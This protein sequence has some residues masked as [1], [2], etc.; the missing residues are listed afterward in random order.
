MAPPPPVFNAPTTYVPG[1]AS[2]DNPGQDL[3]A[4]PVGTAYVLQPVAYAY[5]VI[6]QPVQPGYNPADPY[7]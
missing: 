6:A 7:Q 1:G 5:P 4:P 3:V 2:Y